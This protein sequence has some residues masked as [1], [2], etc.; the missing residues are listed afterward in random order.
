M[1]YIFYVTYELKPRWLKKI[2]K[3]ND[4]IFMGRNDADNPF[5]R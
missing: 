2:E 5:K 4:L 3:G 1:K